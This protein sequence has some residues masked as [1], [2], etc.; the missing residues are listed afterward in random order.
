[1]KHLVIVLFTLTVF[2][3][4][5]GQSKAESQVASATTA[6]TKAMVDGDRATLEKLAADQ[7]GYGHSGGHIDDKKEFVEKIASGNS[8]FLS[9]DLTEQTITISGK[10]AIVR[11]ILTAK[12]HD[13]GK[14]PADVHLRV[15][16]VWQKQGGQWKLLA[17][18]AV[19]IT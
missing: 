17:R 2:I 19:K 15:I 9:I 10:T 18:Q 6:L 3:R 12:T 16:L 8:D 14:A 13:K 4:V 5:Q 11:H 1:M 7:L